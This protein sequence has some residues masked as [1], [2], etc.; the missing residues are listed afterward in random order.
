MI[1]GIL[2]KIASGKSEMLKLLK[3]KG[4]YIISAD[5]I[6]SD[7]YK[8]GA[9]GAMK[10]ANCFGDKFLNKD[11]SVDKNKLRD[12]VFNN[13]DERKYLENIIHPE[14][15]N[16]ILLLLKKHQGR[17][18]AIESVYFDNNFLEDFIDKIYYVDRPDEDILKTLV[19]KRGFDISL[20]KKVL[21]IFDIPTDLKNVIKNNSSLDDFK[22]LVLKT[23]N[24]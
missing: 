22:N 17:D 2:G 13:D 11:G 6:V 18:I 3:K 23:L 9:T 14:V 5:K 10:I 24:L 8:P 7:L 16:E 1:L 4:F 21:D 20:A 19:G 15:Y 12:E